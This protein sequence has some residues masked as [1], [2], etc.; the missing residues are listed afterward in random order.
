MN[1]R[2]SRSAM[3]LRPISSPANRKNGIDIRVNDFSEPNITCGTRK[4]GSPT[5]VR[6]S[7]PPARKHR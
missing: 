4:L 7:T 1:Q 3:P 5:S 6:I 2:I